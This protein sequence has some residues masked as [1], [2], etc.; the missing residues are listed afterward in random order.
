[1]SWL[2][3]TP[4]LNTTCRLPIAG[5]ARVH[6]VLKCRIGIDE[7]TGVTWK[8]VRAIF[9]RVRCSNRIQSSSNIS[10]LQI[11][12][13]QATHLPNCGS[14]TKKISVATSKQSK[15][16]TFNLFIMQMLQ[17]WISTTATFKHQTWCKFAAYHQQLR[18][19]TAG[20]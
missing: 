19:K 9:S 15:C 3:F 7:K 1:M 12:Y 16:A 11:A 4:D 14:T 13:S 10:R 18:H 8:L 6:C 2:K 20:G 5:A 17:L